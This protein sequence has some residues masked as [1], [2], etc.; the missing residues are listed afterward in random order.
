ML[1]PPC[2]A[3]HMEDVLDM[4]S[5]TIGGNMTKQGMKVSEIIIKY[6]R[7]NGFDGLCHVESEC[8]CDI[9]DLQHCDCYC[10]ECEPAYKGEDELGY[11]IYT[12]EKK[13]MERKEG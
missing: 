13:E 2:T 5:D 6:L 3:Y 12:T 11:R 4:V 7:D 9:D 10:M 1:P 8:G